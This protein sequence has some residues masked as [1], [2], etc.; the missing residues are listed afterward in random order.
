MNISLT[1]E[2]ERRIAEMVDSGLYST[3][4]EVVRAALR[5]L[6]TANEEK[7]RLKAQF[8]ADIQVAID[9]LDR[10]EGISPEE[11]YRRVT[12]V[13]DAHRRKAG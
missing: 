3:A 4:S 8:E 1:P 10:G 13:I 5:M 2:F 7:E 9:Q 6:F 11:A 12:E